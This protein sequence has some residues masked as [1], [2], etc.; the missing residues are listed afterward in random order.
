MSIGRVL[1]A[2]ARHDSSAPLA[3]ALLRAGCR[4]VVELDRG[5]QHPT[6]VH[7][8]G[9]STP[10]TGRYETSVLYALGRPMLPRAYR[11]K[12]PGSTQSTKPTLNDPGL[13]KPRK[14]PPASPS[15]SG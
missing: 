5:S 11:W 1:I 2:R 12:P 4:N 15:S 9:S 10:P 14:A 6:F 8:A 7:R 13:P 3:A